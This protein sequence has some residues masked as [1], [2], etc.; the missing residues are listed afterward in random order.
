MLGF[1]N[2]SQE[3][4]LKWISQTWRRDL[5]CHSEFSA[6]NRSDL[7][8]GGRHVLAGLGDGSSG[9]DLPVYTGGI[10]SGL[11]SAPGGGIPAGWGDHALYAWSELGMG[12]YDLIFVIVPHI[13]NMPSPNRF[14]RH[15]Y[16][17]RKRDQKPE[18]QHKNTTKQTFLT[19]FPS[20]TST[21]KDIFWIL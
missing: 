1:G 13:N 20:F 4:I 3:G 18:Q 2:D 17:C 9:G 15:Y 5:L 12:V 10:F 6:L 19:F 11:L 14:T 16:L 8:G 21:L 7:S